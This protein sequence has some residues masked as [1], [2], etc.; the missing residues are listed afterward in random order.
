MTSLYVVGLSNITATSNVGLP[1]IPIIVTETI[2]GAITAARDMVEAVKGF[3]DHHGWVVTYA[4]PKQYDLAK[5]LESLPPL[6]VRSFAEIAC[7]RAGGGMA[8]ASI[9]IR[10]FAPESSEGWR[11][12]LDQLLMHATHKPN[13]G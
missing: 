9:V 6:W 10:H 4:V 8:T 11:W 12:R 2:D 1:E 5:D 3:F 13:Q 7:L